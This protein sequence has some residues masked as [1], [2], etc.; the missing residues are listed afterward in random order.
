[1]LVEHIASFGAGNFGLS[2]REPI[3]SML[4]YQGKR[5]AE[6]QY[7]INSRRMRRVHY[8]RVGDVSK[9]VLPGPEVETGDV[10]TP[11]TILKQFVFMSMK[12]RIART[13]E[14]NHFM[15]STVHRGIVANR[16]LAR[17]G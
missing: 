15:I 8:E 6:K 12:L 1:M 4:W 2:M 16:T 3:T 11:K 5:P 14:S 7:V 9:I 17:C 10:S 13:A